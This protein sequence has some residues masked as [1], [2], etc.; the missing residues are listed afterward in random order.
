MIRP[1]SEQLSDALPTLIGLDWGTSSLRG[2]LFSAAGG[3]LD[4]VAKPWGIQQ[5]P[6]GGFAA[7]F[8]GVAAEWR[9]RGPAL[10]AVA[11]GMVGSRQG[12][13]EVPYVECPA[14]AAAIAR[15]MSKGAFSFF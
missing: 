1:D 9:A 7:A 12:W 14:N 8:A 10:P 6:A 4:A 5:L 15:G 2:Y 13:R 11:A 3:V